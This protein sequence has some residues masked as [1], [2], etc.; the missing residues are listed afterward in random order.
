MSIKMADRPGLHATHALISFVLWSIG[1][2]LFYRQDIMGIPLGV[3]GNGAAIFV[4]AAITLALFA[5]HQ[6]YD[7]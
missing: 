5:V 7:L 2:V 3:A 6:R 4:L 1:M